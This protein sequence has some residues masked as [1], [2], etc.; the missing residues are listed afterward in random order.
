MQRTLLLSSS[1]HSHRSSPHREPYR[2]AKATTFWIDGWVA[3]SFRS[4]W[5]KSNRAWKASK[6]I[7]AVLL[8]ALAD[9]AGSVIPMPGG[10]VSIEENRHFQVEVNGRQME[11]AVSTC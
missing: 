6:D 11:D 2:K 7:A 10:G 9:W 8:R 1:I 5:R 4:S 3:L